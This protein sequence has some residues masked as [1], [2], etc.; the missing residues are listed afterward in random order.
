MSITAFPCLG[1]AVEPQ[2]RRVFSAQLATCEQI[3]RQ[4]GA[5]PADLAEF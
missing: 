4:A 3:L 2:Q 1:V 5:T